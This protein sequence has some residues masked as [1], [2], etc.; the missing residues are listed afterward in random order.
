MKA[1]CMYLPQ[2]HTFPENDKWWGEGYTEW[3]AVKRG[4]PLFK[5]HVQ[6][7]RP[8]DGRYYDLGKDGEATLRWQASL[9]EKYGIYGFAFYQ[10][11]FKG[12]QLMKRPMEI[13][14]DHPDI[15][16]RYCI[17]WANES[18]T[19]TWYGLS[20]EVIMKQDYGD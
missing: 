12:E 20:E 3:T 7:R 18:W 16:L 17:C 5:G 11:W 9:A 1:I 19:R 2:Y 13:L 8:L 15:P 6:P 10:Y 4:R 14:R